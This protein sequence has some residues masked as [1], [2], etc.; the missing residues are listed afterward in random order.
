[1]AVVEQLAFDLSEPLPAWTGSPLHYHTE[2]LDPQAHID[3]Y[4]R[5][6]VENDRLDC[7]RRSGMWRSSMCSAPFSTANGHTFH[8]LSAD[9]RRYDNRPHTAGVP[10]ALMYQVICQDCKWHAI[11]T[12]E[13]AAVEAWHEHAFPHWRDLPIMPI[14]LQPRDW[15]AKPTT[16]MIAWIETNYPFEHRI[17]GAP[18][19]TARTGIGT[20]H[21]GGRSP[22][23]GYDLGTLVDN[24]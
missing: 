18:L 4:E 10:D 19:R 3:A 1:V 8:L 11:T 12:S 17:G 9:C 20:R 21:V 24:E 16:R 13:N 7:I 22:F 6:I 15:N 14:K 2:Y 23:G 5:W